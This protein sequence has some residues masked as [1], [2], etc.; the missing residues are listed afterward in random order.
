[1]TERLFKQKFEIIH[2]LDGIRWQ[3]TSGYYLINFAYPNNEDTTELTEDE[4]LLT[5]WLAYIT[6]RQMPFQQIWDKGGLIFSEIVHTYNLNKSITH[7]TDLESGM[8][9][10]SE[11]DGYEFVS[12]ISY[13]SLNDEQ[14]R[15]LDPY[16]SIEDLNKAQETDMKIAFR[17]RFYTDDYLC[18]LYTLQTLS[19]EKFSGSFT[20]YLSLVI[21]VVYNSACFENSEKIR[22]CV[23]GMAYALYRLTYDVSYSYDG[24]RITYKNT[25]E[26][27]LNLEDFL[28]SST[29]YLNNHAQSVI[30][31]IFDA[32]AES[33]AARLNNFF[34]INT[35]DKKNQKKYLSM[36][37]VWCSLRDYLKSPE[38]KRW[39]VSCIKVHL[40]GKVDSSFLDKLFSSDNNSSNACRYL[41]LPGDVWNENS[42]F[43]RC[44]T[45]NTSGKL[46]AVLRAEYDRIASHDRIGYPEEFDTTFDFVPRMCEKNNCDICPFGSLKGAEIDTEKVEKLCVAGTGKY[47]PMVLLYCGYYYECCGSQENCVLIKY[48]KCSEQG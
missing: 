3:E 42:I 34:D 31:D 9:Q 1:M 46:G 18:M 2:F 38:Y 5:H 39:F 24:K 29:L 4:K 6:D 32:D 23:L 30:A 19:D 35:P 13:S 12:H 37:R 28:T 45:C 11:E 26:K 8:F 44:I 43:R 16:Y 33:F 15:R 22:Y 21:N 25:T 10:K 47:C 48:L 27:S 36:K 20:K 7:L 40:K 17:S 41:E 14:K